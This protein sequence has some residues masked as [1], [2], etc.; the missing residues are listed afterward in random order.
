MI[1]SGLNVYAYLTLR[2]VANLGPNK[3]LSP[4]MRNSLS[5]TTR[6]EK[7]GVEG[8]ENDN[9]KD[10][11]ANMENNTGTIYRSDDFLNL[12]ALM[13]HEETLNTE[14]WLLRT[15]ISIFLLKSLQLSQFFK[16]IVLNKK[17][18]NGDVDNTDSAMTDDIVHDELLSEEELLVCK[19]ILRLINICPTNCHDVSEFETPVLDAFTTACNKVSIGAAIYPTL[20]L[21]NHACDPSFMRCN[22]GNGVVCVANRKILKGKIRYVYI[23]L[24]QSVDLLRTED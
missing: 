19:V 6:S 4:Y 10:R 11:N 7:K 14:E 2:A 15:L 5:E 13:A 8:H 9:D 23:I 1:E 16:N 17:N 3:L 20:A 21:F 12:Y 18:S 22:K 24:K